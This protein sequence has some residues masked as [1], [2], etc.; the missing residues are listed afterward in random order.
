MSPFDEWSNFLQTNRAVSPV[1]GAA[2]MLVI[3]ALLA[4]IL[5]VTAFGFTDALREP[6]P[7]VAFETDYVVDGA[8]NAPNGAYIN[9]S[10]SAGDVADGS[11]VYVR[12]ESG[13]EVAWEDIWTGTATVA[14]GGYVHVDG[15]ESDSALDPVCEAGQTYYVVVERQDGTTAILR[16]V[17]VP[18]DPTATSGC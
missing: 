4:A 12:D 17:T 3:V 13:N 15:H 2:L 7:Q 8:G 5:A 11:T 10:H 14:P 1:V 6:T 16:E 9:I 18:R